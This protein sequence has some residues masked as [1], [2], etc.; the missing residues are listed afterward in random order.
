MKKSFLCFTLCLLI[1][2][3][4]GCVNLYYMSEEEMADSNVLQLIEYLENEDS[5]GVKSL[6]APN[7]LNQIDDIDT[8][9]NEL[10]LYYNG[11]FE[12]MDNTGL[13]TK[14]KKT[15]G[16]KT[17]YLSTSTDVTTTD[18]VYRIAM[19]WYV[20]DSDDENNLGIWS[21]YIIKYE[22]D[23]NTSKYRGDGLWTPG[24]NIGK[25]FYE[26]NE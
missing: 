4:T 14:S 16:V 1:F 19:N 3:L 11:D 23:V 5:E 15:D 17:K 20:E 25:V 7:I 21:L 18:N 24:V 8:M 22:D 6:F 9:I 26:P 12:S 10:I 13:T 2:I